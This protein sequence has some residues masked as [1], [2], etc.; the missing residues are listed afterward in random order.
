M[1]NDP[2]ARRR[3]KKRK[4]RLRNLLKPPNP[5]NLRFSVSKCIQTPTNADLTDFRLHAY[6]IRL[7][8]VTLK[9]LVALANP[10]PFSSHF[11]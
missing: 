5:L 2:E 11:C 3:L 9:H 8:A 1:N 6:A 7:F 4:E 10:F